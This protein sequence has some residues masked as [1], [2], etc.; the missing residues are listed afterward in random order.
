MHA[1]ESLGSVVEADKDLPKSR[2]YRPNCASIRWTRLR[3]RPMRVTLATFT[4]SALEN[5]TNWQYHQQS[6]PLSY[7]RGKAGMQGSRRQAH[8]FNHPPHLPTLPIFDKSLP[9]FLLLDLL[10][11]FS[12][13][14]I[15]SRPR[16]RLQ[17]PSIRHPIAGLYLHHQENWA[18]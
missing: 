14:G 2:T 15:F 4:H 16:Y 8:Y 1:T 18:A 7:H 12:I 3:L 9:L 13:L 17:H 10:A 5:Y 6:R 11:F